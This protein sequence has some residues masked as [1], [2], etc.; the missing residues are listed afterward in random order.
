VSWVPHA[1]ATIVPFDVRSR[2]E[3]PAGNGKEV[4]T[5]H[6]EPEPTAPSTVGVD[7]PR[8][9]LVKPGP[10]GVTG[11]DM[12][13]PAQGQPSPAT[14]TT[15]RGIA[16]LTRGMKATVEGRV[17][18]VQIRPAQQN[19]VLAFDVEDPT[20]QLT[21][22]YYGRSRIA[23]IDCGSRLRL[24]GRVGAADGKPVM[25]NPAYQLLSTQELHR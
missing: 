25:I 7:P 23:G 21:V 14:L 13:V 20:G 2:L 3:R 4:A 8:P 11:G 15:I 1:A 17:R 5:A 6:P 10:D 24:T 16:S 12:S 18:S 9:V 19:T 22:L